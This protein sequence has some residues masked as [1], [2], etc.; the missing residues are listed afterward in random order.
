MA[1]IIIMSHVLV[2]KTG[3]GLVIEFIN[4][5]QVVITITSNTAPD[6]H[7]FTPLQSSQSISTCLHYSF[8][9]NGSQHRNYHTLN[10]Q[11]LHINQTF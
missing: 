3:F 11:M 2:T 5:L 4:R 9:G 1:C 10:L 7:T 6:L 8:L